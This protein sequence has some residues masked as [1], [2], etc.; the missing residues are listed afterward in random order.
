MPS[1]KVDLKNRWLAAVLA[2]LFPGAGHLYQGRNFKAT[3]YSIGVIGLFAWGLGLG[4]WKVVYWRWES[5][6][7]RT[8]GYLAQVLVGLPALPAAWQSHRYEVPPDDNRVRFQQRLRLD[9]VSAGEETLDTTFRGRLRFDPEE[10]SIHPVDERERSGP[11]IHEVQGTL[12]WQWVLD[13][14]VG[15]PVFE[16]TFNGTQADGRAVTLTLIREPSVSPRVFAHSEITPTMLR[17]PGE[18]LPPQFASDRR[19]LRCDFR[20]GEREGTIEGSVPRSFSDWFQVPLEEKALRELHRRLGRRFELAQVFT[21]IAGL[22]NLLAIWDAL[23]GPAYGYG[24]EEEEDED[25][26]EPDSVPA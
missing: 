9:R 25:N 11:P 12:R 22:L 16:G 8:F 19:Y 14:A 23:E 5:G 24:D 17:N 10:V 2:F 4:E 21:W 26:S 18:D 13:D 1:S 15:E 3:I 6:S 7:H 20:E